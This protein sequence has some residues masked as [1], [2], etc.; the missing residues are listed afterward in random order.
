MGHTNRL[1]SNK[2][3]RKLS[4]RHANAVKDY[5]VGKD[6]PPHRIKAEGQVDTQPI[7]RTASGAL[8][9]YTTVGA[10]WF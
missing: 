2:Y 3:A 8:Q 6:V 1:A 7:P 9:N 10:C 5:V 4:Q